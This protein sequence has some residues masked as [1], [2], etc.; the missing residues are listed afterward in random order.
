M[1]NIYLCDD[2]QSHVEYY[3]KIIKNFLLFKDWDI[4]ISGTFTDPFALIN[5]VRET[6]TVGL[7]FLD[8]ELETS[9][10]GF[11]TAEQIRSI[12]PRGFIVFITTH[13]E[14]QPLAFHY[15]VEAMDYILKDNPQNVKT[16][17]L[18]C[19]S[20][21]YER[22]QL[23]GSKKPEFISFQLKNHCIHLPKQEIISICA[24]TIPHQVEIC[25]ANSIYHVYETLN[26]LET[27]LNSDFFR[28][29]KSCIVNLTQIRSINKK[30]HL[31]TMSNGICVPVSLRNLKPLLE[32]YG[33]DFFILNN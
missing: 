15:R 19:V 16:H 6:A 23:T 8:I 20:L 30:E 5:S 24:S 21:A 13:D 31:I 33:R 26:D 4:Q 14:M 9:I 22:Y 28:C 10:N 3:A 25:T 7:Y 11:E 2:I 12:D 1:L 27:R 32:Q 18:H 17:L 29:H